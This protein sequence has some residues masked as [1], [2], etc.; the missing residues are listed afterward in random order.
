[1]SYEDFT[2][3]SAIERAV[4][5]EEY[6][7]YAF[8]EEAYTSGALK[9]DVL[10]EGTRD[11]VRTVS[12]AI[13]WPADTDDA[14]SDVHYYTSDSLKDN[15][16]SYGDDDMHLNNFLSHLRVAPVAI[17]EQGTGSL[18]GKGMDE[19]IYGTT[20]AL[21]RANAL[22]PDLFAALRKELEGTKSLD[23]ETVMKLDDDRVAYGVYMAYRIMGRLVTTQDMTV[24][25]RL[26]GRNSEKISSNVT[27]AHREVAA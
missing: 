2:A 5:D 22:A 20:P 26:M 16:F 7:R 12:E 13:G 15:L 4:R 11:C 1:M 18:T 3:T 23:S 10:D 14:I 8:D 6:A 25:A 9:W 17:D 19:V 21:I 27:S 24:R